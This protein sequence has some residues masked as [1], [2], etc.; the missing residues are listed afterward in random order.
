M[1]CAIL[2]MQI[3]S[4]KLIWAA[5]FYIIVQINPP[6]NE[7]SNKRILQNQ[8]WVKLVS[9][10]GDRGLETATAGLSATVQF[11][12]TMQCSLDTQA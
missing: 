7:G 3:I 1:G 11:P 2:H 12:L 5:Q 9:Y 10:P 6:Q 8:R 4:Q